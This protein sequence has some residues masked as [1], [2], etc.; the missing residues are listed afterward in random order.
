MYHRKLMLFLSQIHRRL[1]KSPADGWEGRPKHATPGRYRVNGNNL[2]DYRLDLV[3]LGFY[4]NGLRFSAAN[5]TAAKNINKKYAIT[6]LYRE[7]GI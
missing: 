3:L 4:F 6:L 1:I 5:V 7:E 2:Y